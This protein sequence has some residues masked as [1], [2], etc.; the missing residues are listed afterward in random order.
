MN[1]AKISSSLKSSL[2]RRFSALVSAAQRTDDET[3]KMVPRMLSDSELSRLRSWAQ[4]VLTN[5]AGDGEKGGH[6]YD[7]ESSSL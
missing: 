5:H 7:R 2:G 1:T 6:E 3:R 4:E